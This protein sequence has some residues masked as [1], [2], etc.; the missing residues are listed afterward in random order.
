M[1]HINDLT[2][3]I[4][5]RLLFDQATVA[6]PD[7]A[8]V[9]LVG[10]NGS[11]KSTLL[12]LILG[13]IAP[14]AGSITVR[15]GARIGTVAQEAPG[16]EESLLDVVLAADAERARL[17]REAE[18]TTDP[19]R[20]G[21][22]HTRLAD[23]DAHAAPAR[24]ARILAGL[25]FSER[26]MHAPCAALSGGWRM[27]VA[28]AAA[29]FARPDLLL[30]D[31]PSNYL[32]L[33][34]VLWLKQFLRTYP[35]TVIIVSHDRELLD[36]SV[37][38]IVHLSKGK[39]EYYSGN[40]ETFMRV[41]AERQALQMKLRKKQEEK[42]R[43]ME[44]F[45][46]RF[47]AK[48]SKARQAQ[49]RLKALERMQMVEAV[50]EEHVAPF[51]FP[52]PARAL[53]PPLI[54]LQD[55]SVG[56]EGRPVLSGIDLRIDPDDR[57][58][59]L[60][61]N[62]QGK[63]TLA[64]LLA[65]R[66]PPLSGHMRHHKKMRAGYFAQ[67]QM[68]ELRPGW[69]PYRY[70]R[71]LM[72]EATEAQVRARLGQHGFGADLADNRVETLSG[73]EKARLLF[74]LAAFHGPH[75]LI[76]DEPTNHLDI[77]ARQALV[78][79]L[80]DYQGAVVLIS[81]DRRLIETVA[82]RLWLVD[83]GTV[84]PFEGDLADYERLVLER[85]RAVRAARREERRKRRDETAPEANGPRKTPLRSP[86]PP[87]PGRLRRE[88]A[89]IEKQMR[90]IEDKIRVFDEALDGGR[91]YAEDAHKAARFAAAREELAARL[92]TL[93]ERWLELSGLLE[94]FESNT[95]PGT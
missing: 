55:V 1:L 45:I 6:I 27:R 29:L 26:Q 5:G 43:R 58:A 57:I 32:D 62:G 39:L 95:P 93:E 52:S 88:I 12:R 18:E 86:R 16:G 30:L 8:R 25:G 33:E 61:A 69:T 48:A 89:E 21:E 44:A 19:H 51:H 20:I 41:R 64:R 34:G 31:E 78:E 60:G 79:A 59:L 81:H 82:D 13:E 35:H 54:R 7:G 68:D 46:A 10:R 90:D 94:T 85:A 2:Y 66:L 23:I 9:G 11:G 28:L 72:P 87:A 40:F 84:R 49:S 22:I 47:R 24:A 38:A 70:F 15:K 77:E 75:I 65:G 83:A 42:R 74:A 71:E 36:E 67:H 37:N 53:N 56:Y 91:L 76:L 63:S 17:L 14:D 92:G 4:E 50:V 80:G 3:R 73:G